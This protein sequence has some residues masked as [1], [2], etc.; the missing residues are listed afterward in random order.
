MPDNTA[1]ENTSNNPIASSQTSNSQLPNNNLSK[2]KVT[3]FSWKTYWN[4]VITLALVAVVGL[5]GYCV[6]NV[7]PTKANLVINKVDKQ[8]APS[9]SSSTIATPS[10]PYEKNR[11]VIQSPNN[12]TII[13]NP[14]EQS[15]GTED[16]IGLFGLVFNLFDNHFS[17]LLTVLSILIT[18]FGLGVPL[19]SYIFQRQNLKDERLAIEKELEKKTKEFDKKLDDYQQQISSATTGIEGTI[20]SIIDEKIQN[21]NT[22]ISEL[23]LAIKN[24]QKESQEN[25]QDSVLKLRTN[26]NHMEE[27]L[28]KSKNEYL[29]FKQ[30]LDSYDK[31]LK[32]NSDSIDFTFGF[33]AEQMAFFAKK[34]DEYRMALHYDLIAAQK[35]AKLGAFSRTQTLLDR[36]RVYIGGIKNFGSIHGFNY[37][38]ILDDLRQLCKNE[39]AADTIESISSVLRTAG[40]K[41][42]ECSTKD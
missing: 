36:I 15:Q 28:L 9:V 25:V 37:A 33:F 1:P 34:N 7:L 30:Y 26:E 20:D 12:N 6:V 3:F 5:M 16:G 24:A 39:L 32:E 11:G 29:Q 21:S 18:I 4:I 17:Q 22:R 8:S 27:M 10:S 42:S 31:T 14:Q 13:I 23:E 38:E 2:P 40:I 41:T 19:A 35:F